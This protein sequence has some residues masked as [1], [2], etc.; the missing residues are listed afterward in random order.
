MQLLLLLLGRIL[1]G[2]VNPDC[3]R[4]LLRLV[5]IQCF[6]F[7]VGILY[8]SIIRRGKV[9]SFKNMTHTPA[10]GHIP[11]SNSYLDNVLRWSVVLPAGQT[12]L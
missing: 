7:C 9:V 3:R 10:I 12:L 5:I 4:M 11:L 2:N 8:Y 1:T 6:V